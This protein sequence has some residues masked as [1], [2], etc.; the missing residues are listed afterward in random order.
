MCVV[1]VL[2]GSGSDQ[3]PTAL[4][5]TTFTS[6]QPCPAPLDLAEEM[7]APDSLPVFPVESEGQPRVTLGQGH[8][9]YGDRRHLVE[10]AGYWEELRE[11]FKNDEIKLDKKFWEGIIL[12]EYM[13]VCDF[14]IKPCLHVNVFKKLPL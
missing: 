12:A 14:I 11:Q 4:F 5:Q 7:Y 10:I 9:A 3:L 6:F 13:G 2:T 1:Y 8:V